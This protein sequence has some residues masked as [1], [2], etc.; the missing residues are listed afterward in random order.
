MGQSMK[1]VERWK[2]E[3]PT[4]A[5]MLP[6]DKY[7][8]FDRKVKRYREGIHSKSH[9]PSG[10]GHAVRAKR[11]SGSPGKVWWLTFRRGAKVDKSQPTTES[12]RFLS[13][14]RRFCVHYMLLYGQHGIWRI[15]G[16]KTSQIRH[17]PVKAT[18][19]F[20]ISLIRACT[21]QLLLGVAVWVDASLLH[22]WRMIAF[23]AFA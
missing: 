22:G 12:S 14:E 9:T 20:L 21:V 15:S 8:V 7:T 6:K 5:E 17:L 23:S 4:E 2:M 16:I 18:T 13:G 10:R 3:M 1:K 11:A 19:S